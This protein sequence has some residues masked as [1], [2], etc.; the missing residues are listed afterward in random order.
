MQERRQANDVVADLKRALNRM[1]NHVRTERIANACAGENNRAT[2]GAKSERQNEM[3]TQNTNKRMRARSG[4]LVPLEVIE[5]AVV[6]VL[7]D[8]GREAKCIQVVQGVGALLEGDWTD[9]DRERT[10]YGVGPRWES[11]VRSSG[12]KLGQDGVLEWAGVPHGV[13]R[14]AA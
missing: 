4:S 13:W 1:N 8:L 6:L 5:C 10:P 2:E 3:N 12:R 11:R 7:E 14:L 9:D